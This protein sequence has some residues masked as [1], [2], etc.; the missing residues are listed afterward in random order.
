MLKNLAGLTL[1]T[2]DLTWYSN[3]TNHPSRRNNKGN[4]VA[5]EVNESRRKNLK[6]NF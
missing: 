3:S 2:L 5:R 6:F 1:K 4:K